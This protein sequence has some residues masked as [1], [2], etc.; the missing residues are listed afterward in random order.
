MQHSWDR[1]R[2]CFV[3]TTTA[4]ASIASLSNNTHRL[5][6]VDEG[7]RWYKVAPVEH[8]KFSFQKKAAET[9]TQQQIEEDPADIFWALMKNLLTEYDPSNLGPIRVVFLATYLVRG[10]KNA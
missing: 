5:L 1:V 6:I 4:F 3:P 7:Q 2:R 8:F 10:G 9:T